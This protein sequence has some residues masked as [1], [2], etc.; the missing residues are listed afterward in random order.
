MKT[1]SEKIDII[2]HYTNA[3]VR[4]WSVSQII[5]AYRFLVL[6]YGEEE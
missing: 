2:K 3:D 5:K 1:I 4:E 6:Q